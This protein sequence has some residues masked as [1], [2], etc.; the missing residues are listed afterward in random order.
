MVS[1]IKRIRIRITNKADITPCSNVLY[2][3]FL[4]TTA[5]IER[6]IIDARHAV[7]NRYRGQT[8]AIIECI[9]ADTCH[10]IRMT[11]IGNCFW[12]N[13]IARV[14]I[15]INFLFLFIR[16]PT[17]AYS[18]FCIANNVVINPFALGINNLNVMGESICSNHTY[19]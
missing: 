8:C 2:Y 15:E 16:I 7:G 9:M 19:E 1:I 13:N 12:Y 11:I 4:Q 14:I 10:S 17:I 18:K 6:S 3:H 5:I